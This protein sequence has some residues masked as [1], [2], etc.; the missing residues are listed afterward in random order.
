M[1]NFNESTVEAA[2][3][4][5]LSELGYEI[6][7]G[8]DTLPGERQ[9]HEEVILQDRLEEALAR[10][11]PGLPLEVRREA[12]ARLTRPEPG[13]LT[14]TNR[15]LHDLII[16][17][18]PVEYRAQDG[19]LKGGRVRVIGFDADSRDL[20]EFV[21]VNQF[22]VVEQHKERR[23]D[24]VVFLNGLPIAVL[25]LKNAVNAKA[26]L[27][28][29]F[30]QLQ[31]YKQQ[32]PT[33]FATNALLVISDGTEA[34]LGSL[35]ATWERFLP[36]R[37][38][39]GMEI[40]AH[41]RPELHVLLEGVFEK[42]RLLDLLHYFI[43]FED[44]A[45]KIAGYHQ[46]HAVRTAVSETLRAA[47]EG[48]D[49]RGG[50]IWHTQGSGKSLTMAFY[51]GRVVQEPAL[52]NPT[53][54][55]LTDRN[56]LDDQ[57]FGTFSRCRDMLRQTPVQAAS[58]DDLRA[59]LRIPHGNVVFTTI[60]KFSVGER[61]QAFPLL[62]NRR[63]IIVIADE[64]HRSQYD[65][66]DGYAAHIR[67]AL[68]QATF[69]GFTGTPIE[70]ADR[71]TRNV[72]GDYISVYDIRRAVDDRATV[73]IYYEGRLARLALSETERPHLDAD[74]EE[75][76]ESAESTV[77]EQIKRKWTQLEAMVG[78]PTRLAQVAADILRHFDQRLEVLDGKGMIVAMSR[79][80]AVELYQKIA[81]HRP[82]WHSND[83]TTGAI[84]VVMTGEASDPEEWQTHIRTKTQLRA[85]AQRLKD[86]EDP[87]K[88]VIVR[89]MW[90]TGFDAPPLHTLYVDKP[91]KGHTLMQAIAR[92]NRVYRDKPG[93]LIVD[94]LGIADQLKEALALYTESGGQGKVF[95]DQ[96]EA[97]R[98][99]Q[100]WHEV[101]CE[102]FHG[103]DWAGFKTG[104]ASE[105]M[106]LLPAA[107]E[108]IVA[109]QD[110]RDRFM[111][112]CQN[113]SQSFALAVAHDETLR[114][115]DDVAFFQAVRAGLL[116]SS[117]SESQ[118]TDEMHHAVRQIVSKAILSEEVVDIF[119]AAGLQHPNMPILSDEFLAEVQGLP[120]KNLAVETLRKLLAG[121]IQA[122]SRTNVVQSKRLSEMLTQAIRA[123]ENRSLETAVILQKLID[124][125]KDIRAAD[126]R[127]EAL[128]LSREEIAF[129]DALE[130]ND[131]A[132][133]ILGDAVL[134]QI[135]R[136]LVQKIRQNL[137]IDWNLKDATR[138]GMRIIV[139]RVLR[140]AGYPPDKEAEAVATVLQQAEAVCAEWAV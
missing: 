79:R 140:N 80:I 88:L 112:A 114:L 94:Y 119:A 56:D 63:N 23:P 83:D 37:T 1:S 123:Y 78:A 102:L 3:L 52:E 86:P 36:W 68:P 11:N 50:V 21:A 103:F 34:R 62:S 134:C 104:T 74:F 76:T 92:V 126:Q 108:Q 97:V 138:A 111:M 129:Y 8:P 125:S 99:M 4:E 47:A 131:S 20:N 55:V 115:R 100:E 91:M 19:T 51:A 33:L 101:C 121:E 116:K 14:D 59:K 75:I 135:A 29:A 18:V 139:R 45:K 44:D 35:T 53:L 95:Q 127:G 30:Q 124:I 54:V 28:D 38:V 106:S 122:R 67:E 85:L 64:A 24:I 58:A 118:S 98:M 27:Q 46:F 71:S 16:N 10:L 87:L 70:A 15:R 107:R 133:K 7:H 81:Q 22:T 77:R 40:A 57:L 120:Y 69:I 17:G 41:T 137:T 117:V 43:V 82:E 73:P 66:V 110:G 26:T 32:I 6:V 12:L 130:T 2:A 109:Q 42:E 89:D 65:F 113:L 25:E 84:K 39:E 13:S 128:G 132:V 9:N 72:F 105:Q 31:T 93:G 49:Q 60:Q 61:G 96:E 90:L 136:D 48:G 5:W